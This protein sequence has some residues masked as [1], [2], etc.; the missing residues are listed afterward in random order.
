MG[1]PI[2]KLKVSR[3]ELVVCGVLLLGAAG[4]GVYRLGQA[5]YDMREP[6]IFEEATQTVAPG[7]PISLTYRE[8]GQQCNYIPWNGV[9]EMTVQRVALYPSYA[10]ASAA[11]EDAGNPNGLLN[12]SNKGDPFL[13]VEVEVANVDAEEGDYW[14]NRSNMEAAGIS[15]SD[16]AITLQDG[17]NLYS[18]T[19][20]NDSGSYLASALWC[21]DGASSSEYGNSVNVP[22]GETVHVTLGF[23]LEE[24]AEDRL[25]GA[26]LIYGG[27]IFDRMDIGS[28]TL[29]GEDDEAASQ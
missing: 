6:Q 20:F 2:G 10:D 26:S 22:Q 24:G 21:V 18:E 17:F 15:G 19:P 7:E 23:P 9:V 13:V 25:D 14:W 29:G 28:P 16:G 12:D 1:R 4:F 8:V 5:V 11:E 3:S 27:S